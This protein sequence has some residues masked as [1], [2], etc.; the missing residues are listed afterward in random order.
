ME[1]EEIINFILSNDK[2]YENANFIGYSM[3]QLVGIKKR[4]EIYKEQ[5]LKVKKSN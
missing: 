4:V 3:S 1:R 5:T 2:S